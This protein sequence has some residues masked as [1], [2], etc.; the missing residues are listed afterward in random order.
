MN[1]V[2]AHGVE[3]TAC[4]VYLSYGHVC[5]ICFWHK[6]APHN[7]PPPPPGPPSPNAFCDL[8]CAVLGYAVL[9]ATH[10]ACGVPL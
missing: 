6:Q 7:T 8:G 4:H 2:C 5:S 9:S 10:S 3:H 1:M